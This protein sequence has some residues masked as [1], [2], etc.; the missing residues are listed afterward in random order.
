MVTG[1]GIAVSSGGTRK[2]LTQELQKQMTEVQS[3]LYLR[4]FVTYLNKI[5]THLCSKMRA[6]HQQAPTE[7]D[8]NLRQRVFF[9]YRERRT[10]VGD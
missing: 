10:G 8:Q 5:T 7:C 3:K 2:R 6:K 1:A 4:H 9:V